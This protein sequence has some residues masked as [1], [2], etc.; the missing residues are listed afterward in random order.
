MAIADVSAY[1][2]LSSE[3]VEEIGYELDVIRRDVEESLGAKDSA[4]IRRVIQFQRALEVAARLMIAGS[5][6]KVGWVA[7]TCA[8]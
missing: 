6:S 8:R 2:H 5:R 1:V 4:Y 7:G 3:D